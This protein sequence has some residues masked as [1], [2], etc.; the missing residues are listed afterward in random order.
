MK[1]CKFDGEVGFWVF[2]RINRFRYFRIY[3]YL[4]FGGTKKNLIDIY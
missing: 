3:I 2:T 4:I 1:D